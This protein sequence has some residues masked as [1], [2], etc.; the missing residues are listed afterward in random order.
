MSDQE[1]AGSTQKNTLKEEFY[2]TTIMIAG[3]I[4]L[5]WLCFE[6]DRDID[7][8]GF[9][10]QYD[11]GDFGDDDCLDLGPLDAVESEEYFG[12]A[13]WQFN[14][15]LTN[16]LKS[17]IKM[18]LLEM[19]LV[20]PKHELL[21]HQF[22]SIILNTGKRSQS[23]RSQHVHHGSHPEIQSRDGQRNVRFHQEM[24]LPA[25]R[26]Q[27]P[28]ENDDEGNYRRGYFQT[29]S[30]S[31]R[32]NR[33][34]STR[35]STWPLHEQ[36]EFGQKVFALLAKIYKRISMIDK[37]VVSSVNPQDMNIIGRKLSACLEK[38]P[39]KISVFHRPTRTLNIPNLTFAFDSQQI[40]TVATQSSSGVVSSPDIVYCL[41]YLIWNG[42]YQSGLVK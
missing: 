4:P 42:I 37:G 5:W 1:S 7:Y 35:F 39:N 14:K 36:I 34:C 18:L 23:H 38:K 8:A 3:K 15:A 10:S 19:L 29:P 11:R 2:R 31:P 26:V 9:L 32:G 22:R 13:L 20:S 16:P 40:W 12:A 27:A 21:C 28:H 30:H 17:I 6:E 41:T 24:F 33:P 25:I